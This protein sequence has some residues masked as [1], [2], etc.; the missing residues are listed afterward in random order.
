MPALAEFDVSSFEALFA[1]WGYPRAHAKRLLRRYYDSGGETVAGIQVARELSARIGAGRELPLRSTEVVARRVAGDG[2]VKLLIGL[3]TERR[4]D[5]ATEGADHG[6]GAS[7]PSSL[8]AFVAPSLPVAAPSLSTVE[9]VLMPSH[10]PDRAAGCVSSQVGCAMGCDF[11]ASTKAGVERSLSSGE[12]VEQFL[13][14]RAEALRMGRRL[15]TIVFMGM[16]EPLMNYENVVAA[17]RRIAGEDLGAIGWRHVT[18]STVGIVPGIDRLREEGLGMHLAV[19]LHAPDDETRAAIVPTGK[20]YKVADI[21]AAVQR[22]QM[23]SGRI[24]T[25]EYTLLAGVNDSDAQAE[26]LAERLAACT[27]DATAHRDTRMHVNLIPYN[28]IGPGVS[29]RV[30]R[31]PTDE[32]VASFLAILRERGVVAHVRRTRGEDIEGACGQLRERVGAGG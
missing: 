14:L 32:R 9:C 18:V 13:W 29:G 26:L 27:P 19:S 24:A 1:Q 30:Y 25:I 12:I 20:R 16:G 28:F 17:V 3:A 22:Y 8:R 4:S 10:I 2:T 11:C 31:R 15:Q 23:A 7:S 21:L 5:E 6:G